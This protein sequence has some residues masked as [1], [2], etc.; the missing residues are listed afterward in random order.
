MPHFYMFA[1][2][3]IFISSSPIYVEKGFKDSSIW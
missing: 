1:S 3:I 2:V